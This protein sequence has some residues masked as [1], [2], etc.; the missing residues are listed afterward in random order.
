MSLARDALL[1]AGL[2]AWGAAA[3][4]TAAARS[5]LFQTFFLQCCMYLPLMRGY[6]GCGGRG[7]ILSGCTPRLVS[8]DL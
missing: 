6:F 7:D 2:L 3:A 5:I 1:D 8:Q 4:A